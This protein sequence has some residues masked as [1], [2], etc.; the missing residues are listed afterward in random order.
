MKK[1]SR[2]MLFQTAVGVGAVGLLTPRVFAMQSAVDEFKY[3]FMGTD[4]RDV[5]TSVTNRTIGYGMYFKQGNAF[6][7]FAVNR[8]IAIH[9][10]GIPSNVNYAQGV[11]NKIKASAINGPYF[12]MPREG[13]MSDNL[14]VQTISSSYHHDGNRS[15]LRLIAKIIPDPAMAVMPHPCPL[16]A[17]LIFYV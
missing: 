8:E 10:V 11:V 1:S 17:F 2:R 16:G 5:A 3:S 7:C 14:Q 9:L 12:P 4:M 6:V 13:F 15:Q